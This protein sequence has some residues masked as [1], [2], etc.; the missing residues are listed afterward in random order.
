VEHK[1]WVTRRNQIIHGRSYIKSSVL[2]D[3]C[4]YL[5]KIFGLLANWG[6]KQ[7]WAYDGLSHLGLIGLPTYKTSDGKLVE[8]LTEGL[9]SMPRHLRQKWFTFKQEL[10]TT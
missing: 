8:S 6:L 9:E 3:G 1:G 4:V 2:E 7:P 5:C 10:E